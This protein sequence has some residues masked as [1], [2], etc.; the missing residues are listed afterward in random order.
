MR[1]STSVSAPV[2]GATSAT[3]RR[4]ELVPQSI[5]PTRTVLSPMLRSFRTAV[6]DGLGAGAG[7]GVLTRRGVLGGVQ[8]G[9]RGGLPPVVEHGEGLVTE[10]VD[11]GPGRQRVTDQ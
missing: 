7:A 3:S 8:G 2:D 5:A 6:G 11:A 10:G 9:A 1:R 4:I